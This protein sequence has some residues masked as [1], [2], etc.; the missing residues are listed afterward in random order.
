MSMTL[1]G[2][3]LLLVIGGICGS[4]GSGLVG[5]SHAGC[6]GS[7]ILGFVGA[8]IGMWIAQKAHLP[9]FYVLHVQNESFPV[10]WSIIGSAICAA[11]MS[12]L[13]RRNPYGF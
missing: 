7:I 1:T 2:V 5:Y 12:I 11:G 4:I 9:T 6:L 3:V 8:W 13:T 10:V